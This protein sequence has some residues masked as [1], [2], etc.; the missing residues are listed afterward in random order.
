M[1]SHYF[2]LLTVLFIPPPVAPSCPSSCAVRTRAASRALP[3][4]HACVLAH[5][6]PNAP[7]P[8]R[9]LPVHRLDNRNTHCTTRIRGAGSAKSGASTRGW[10]CGV[11]GSCISR[12]CMFGRRRLRPQSPPPPPQSDTRRVIRRQQATVHRRK[13][14]A[15]APAGAPT[16]HQQC[17]WTRG[18]PPHMPLH[19]PPPPPPTCPYTLPPHAGV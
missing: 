10:P 2:T 9:S 5:I 4:R 16:G 1:G 15:L 18:S 14:V 13:P 12:C 11:T 19:P 7:P 8:P 3:L 17:A 6:A